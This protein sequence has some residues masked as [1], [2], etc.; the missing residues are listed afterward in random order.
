MNREHK[1]SEKKSLV[2]VGVGQLLQPIRQALTTGM[3]I[4]VGRKAV[5]IIDYALLSWVFR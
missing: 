3:G 2:L 4:K 1:T 5:L